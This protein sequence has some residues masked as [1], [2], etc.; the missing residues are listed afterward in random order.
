MRHQFQ[1]FVGEGIPQGD[2]RDLRMVGVVA[3]NAKRRGTEDEMRP[4]DYR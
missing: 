1:H 4:V 2:D 3:E